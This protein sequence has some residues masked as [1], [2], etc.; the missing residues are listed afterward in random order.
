MNWIVYI[1]E[2]SNKA[3]YTG[4]TNNL[5]ERI[6]NHKKGYGSFYTKKHFPVKLRYYEIHKTRIEAMK[7]EK[8]IKGWTHSKK[9]ALIHNNIEKLKKLSK[10]KKGKN[11]Y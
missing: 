9:E 4:H 8:Q 7:R 1:L 10:R 11:Q 3:F 6:E 2:C 5:S